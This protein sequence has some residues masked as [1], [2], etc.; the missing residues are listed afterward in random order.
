MEKKPII[1]SHVLA[2][3]LFVLFLLLLPVMYHL[4]GSV[5][6]GGGWRSRRELVSDIEL[7]IQFLVLL[8]AGVAVLTVLCWIP[9]R[10]AQGRPHAQVIALVAAGAVVC[11]GLFGIIAL[12]SGLTA[13]G[14]M[15]SGLVVVCACTWVAALIWAAVSPS[16]SRP[17][18][19][20]PGRFLVFGVDRES[21]FD[22]RVVLDADSEKNARI[23]GELRGIV[24][25]SIERI[26]PVPCD[27]DRPQ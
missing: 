10:M 21:G 18:H 8:A 6:L 12:M 19:D 14:L 26:S 27:L 17:V 4:G 7:V 13:L 22:T 2:I 11:G 23:K 1:P 16:P 5:M 9:A 25:S 20:G 3:A 15:A 24:V